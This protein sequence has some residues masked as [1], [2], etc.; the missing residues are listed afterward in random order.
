MASV[1]S[2]DTKIYDCCE[3]WSG[4]PG[5]AWERSFK[6]DFL[7]ALG[8]FSD[9]YITLKGHLQG[10]GPG[11]MLP[12]NAAGVAAGGVPAMTAHAGNAASVRDSSA[13]WV[14]PLRRLGLCVL[15]SL[16]W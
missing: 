10:K 16:F 15:L 5:A 8:Q 4:Q 6:P 9:S 14:D 2:R 3:P 1:N 7:S 12:L 13:A 11:S